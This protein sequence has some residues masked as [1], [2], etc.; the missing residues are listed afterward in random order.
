MSRFLPTFAPRLPGLLLAFCAA[1]LALLLTNNLVWVRS[2]TFALMACTALLL[3]LNRR[4]E[5]ATRATDVGVPLLFIILWF[6]WATA[7]LRWTIEPRF[8]VR[9]WETEVQYAAYLFTAFFIVVRDDRGMKVLATALLAAFGVLATL[10]IAFT[11]SGAFDLT[12]WHHDAGFWSTHLVLVAPVLFALFAKPAG[13]RTSRRNMLLFVVLLTLLLVNARLTD[14]RMVWV[15]LAAAYGT[16][17]VVAALRWRS[18]F[19]RSPWRWM[20][21]LAALFVVLAF[22]LA[23]AARERAE[24]KYAPQTS[25]AQTLQND[26]R[27][28]L[29]EVTVDKIRAQP[30]LGHGFGRGILRHVLPEQLHDPM[31]SHP[32]NTFVGQWLQLGA[33]GLAIFA[34]VMLSLAW[35]YARFVRSRDDILAL[36]GVIGLALLAGFMVKNLTDDFFYR[37]NGKLFWALSALLLAYGSLREKRLETR[38]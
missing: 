18:A 27:F 14:N 29:W 26:P 17:A 28:A 2:V 34:G 25:V 5:M 21:P 38:G 8:S 4:R 33:V 11:W 12:L 19:G 35:R 9:E 15:A 13:A 1:Y 3:I 7:S 31:L 10:A 22:A 24:S 37:S 36:V 30:W 20:A 16:A 32:H 23:D 6:L